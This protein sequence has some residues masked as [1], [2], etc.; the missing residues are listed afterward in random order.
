[1]KVKGISALERHIEKIT[2]GIVGVV[3]IG[4]LAWQFAGGGNTVTVDRRSVPVDQ[5]LKPVVE[6]ANRVRA[7]LESPSP[8]LPELSADVDMLGVFRRDLARGVAPSP[9]LASLGRGVS[10]GVTTGPAVGDTV[11]ATV[12][13]PSPTTPVA[14]VYRNTISPIEWIANEALRPLLPAEQP[15]DKAGV[16]IQV[17]FSGKALAQALDE[18][19]D[20]D[21]PVQPIPPQWWRGSIEVLAVQAEREML[22]PDG[23]WGQST[24]VGPIPGRPD[25][26]AEVSR[27]VSSPGDMGLILDMA[28]RSSESVLRPA[29]LTVLTG[30]AWVE[31]LEAR[32]AGEGSAV[33]EGTAGLVRRRAELASRLARLEQQL[34][35]L[36]TTRGTDPRQQPGGGGKTTGSRPGTA[37][38]ESSPAATEDAA[39]RNRLQ[40]QYDETHLAL[41]RIDAQL[42]AQGL[43]PDGRPMTA[44]QRAMLAGASLGQQ[45]P[46][47][48]DPA[49]NAWT[50][51]LTVAPGQTYR[52][53]V[54]LAFN[55]PYYG[56]ERALKPEQ[57][58]LAASPVWY[59]P[60]SEWAEVP[61]ERM[62]NVFVV[63]ASG[64]GAL[65]GP[66]AQFEVFKFYYGYDRRTVVSAEPGDQIAA[67]IRPPPELLIFDLEALKSSEGVTPLMPAQPTRTPDPVDPRA[68]RSPR[69]PTP[70]STPALP[71]GVP[72][73]PPAQPVLGVPVP[74]TIPVGDIGALLLDVVPVPGVA[75]ARSIPGQAAEQRYKVILLDSLTGSIVARTP[76]EER[77]SETYAKLVRS[78]RAG[79]RQAIPGRPPPEPKPEATPTPQPI[80]EPE[81]PTR[82]PGGGGGGGGGG[83]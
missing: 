13:P 6:A 41:T 28:R 55:N 60:W 21:G 68:P 71:S 74:R 2:V 1:M 50:H 20:S 82:R 25:L 35:Q 16:S 39:R 63:A 47:L 72:G 5:A 30:E 42:A 58:G 52:Y 7:E 26:L 67:E 12:T 45:L 80:P 64:R 10:I 43:N 15:F 66:K 78:A 70:P 57:Q 53:R 31:P 69:E 77:G 46:L 62:E 27:L 40:R 18:D 19:P 3:G 59:T 36:G 37:P 83:G 4:A 34:S 54:R 11:Y 56:H 75:A 61:V 51:D 49:V 8:R 76:E 48:E 79:E 44:E 22:L 38:R 29:Y 81:T 32:A 17:Q 9:R 73:G 24:I 33:A 23:S 65:G 14:H